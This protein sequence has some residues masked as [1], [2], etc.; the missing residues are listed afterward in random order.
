MSM[1]AGLIMLLISTIKGID[2]G[3]NSLLTWCYY[4][5]RCVR[6]R[7]QIRQRRGGSGSTCGLLILQPLQELIMLGGMTEIKQ[8]GW[9]GPAASSKLVIRT[10]DSVMM[11]DWKTM[12]DGC[13]SGLSD[14]MIFISFHLQRTLSAQDK[15]RGG[16][17]T[18]SG[19]T[20]RQLSESWT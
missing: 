4:E 2:T 18:H 1:L 3:M 9:I 20:A 12:I 15:K 11:N 6:A 8:C 19:H 17:T 14:L 10:S 7:I 16:H 13:C 5:R